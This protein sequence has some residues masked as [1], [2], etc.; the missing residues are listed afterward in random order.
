MKQNSAIRI[1]RI[2]IEN[3]KNVELGEIKISR[4]SSLF[5]QEKASSII[6]LYG[7]NGSGKT[8]LI[9]ALAVLKY[10]LSGKAIPNE[11]FDQ[12]SIGKEQS[13]LEFEFEL[14]L[15]QSP[16]N[17]AYGFDLVRKDTD[18]EENIIRERDLVYNDSNITPSYFNNENYIN[19]ILHST[20]KSRQSIE[21][22]LLSISGGSFKRKQDI[23]KVNSDLNSYLDNFIPFEPKT[24]YASMIP[25]KMRGL[26]LNSL[27]DSIKA[28][29]SFIFSSLIMFKLTNEELSKEEI[30]QNLEIM[31][32][33]QKL[34]V[35]GHSKLC[36][37]DNSNLQKTKISIQTGYIRTLKPG[38]IYP[39]SYDIDL[40]KPTTVPEEVF[41]ILQDVAS[42][43]NIVLQQIIPG[44]TMEFK[45]IDKEFA[46][47]D[48]IQI[49]LQPV[50]IRK[51][52]PIP[53]RDESEGIKKIISV[54]HILITAYNDQ[55][56]TFAVD[57][58]DSGIFE[59]LLGEILDLFESFGKGQLIF[60]SHNLRPLEVLNKKNI[61][62]TTTNPKKRYIQMSNIETNHNLRLNYYRSIQLGG[63]KEELYDETDHI[64]IARAFRNAW[65]QND[66][67]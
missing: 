67:K 8:A 23:I 42:A 50:I 56:T 58:L 65:W 66:K 52:I 35:F 34:A 11:Y 64:E 7:Q 26:L 17:V 33:M 25:S 6:A 16:Y 63:Q 28:R 10:C 30:Q 1:S 38:S 62:F 47:N 49:R 31:N 29:K 19:N 32:I 9:N 46:E 53:L 14:Y 37:R 45:Q 5:N 61:Y 3:F 21:N 12:I 24:R 39:N 40:N 59:F 51:G 44:L 48:K 15:D 22:E 18:M 4:D 27:L 41:Y 13:R 20:N 2:K 57:E 43:M 60:T 36:V 54:L 55:S